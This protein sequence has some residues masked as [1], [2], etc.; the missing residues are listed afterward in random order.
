M[1][2]L[3]GVWLGTYWQ[4]KQPVR[5]EMTLVQGGNSL[6]GRVLD[7]ND[8]GSAL[9]AGKVSGRSV[10]FTK[11]Y[12]TASR[13]SVEYTGTLS[14]D[15]KRMKGQWRI[16][17]FSGGTWEAQRSDEELSLKQITRRVEKVPGAI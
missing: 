10:N 7:D 4:R 1:A 12:I 17:W 11:T 8:L 15:G 5:F 3:S 9:L 2:D 16:S 14:E 13:H 6:S